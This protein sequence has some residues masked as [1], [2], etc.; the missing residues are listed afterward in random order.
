MSWVVDAR[1]LIQLQPP[2]EPRPP[3]NELA[4]PSY[5]KCSVFSSDQVSKFNTSAEVFRMN[6]QRSVGI[7]QVRYFPDHFNRLGR[8]KPDSFTGNV[9]DFYAYELRRVHALMHA[10][11]PQIPSRFYCRDKP[12]MTGQAGLCHKLCKNYLDDDIVDDVLCAS[13]AFKRSGFRFWKAWY[14][15]C[16]R[17]K[18]INEYIDGCD[19][20]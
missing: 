2:I 20:K 17:N 19:L 9:F 4:I 8:G 15:Q 6:D 16:Y 13:I 12:P 10:I 5:T 7:F 3:D 18:D 14:H 11:F 1:G